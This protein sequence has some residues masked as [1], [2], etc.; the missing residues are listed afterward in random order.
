MIEETAIVTR[1]DHG[2]VWIKS[3]P[4]SACA[5]CL[6]HSS[7]GTATLSKLL[8]KRE[9]AVNCELPLKIGDQV[10]VALDDTGL[11]MGALLVYLLPLLVMLLM[12]AAV[13]EFSTA[14]AYWLPEVA[15]LSLLMTFWCIRRL[16]TIWLPN[17]RFR[18]LI[19]AKC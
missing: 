1:V 3:Q 15:L 5:G 12:V 17:N 13:N 19:V 6:Q 7:C 18:L 4:G 8:P 16:H 11:L 14:S 10:R 9:F 2:R